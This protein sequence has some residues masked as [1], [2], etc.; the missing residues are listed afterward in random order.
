MELKCRKIKLIHA[1]E[2]DLGILS[3]SAHSLDSH[4]LLS[5]SVWGRMQVPDP[6]TGAAPRV[7]TLADSVGSPNSRSCKDQTLEFRAEGTIGV[8]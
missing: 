3:F 2:L 4:T 6:C 1:T 5:F 7:G 8:Q